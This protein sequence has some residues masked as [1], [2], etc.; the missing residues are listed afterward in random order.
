MDMWVSAAILPRVCRDSDA[1]H[2]GRLRFRSLF[3]LSELPVESTPPRPRAQD[4]PKKPTMGI[5]AGD[6]ENG[7][8]LFKTRCLQCHTVEAVR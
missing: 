8:K 3:S 2:C 5:P 6:V 7:A 1:S 4:L